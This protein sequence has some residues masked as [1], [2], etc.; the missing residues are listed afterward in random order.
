[1]EL[2]ERYLNAVRFWLPAEQQ[3]DIIAEL[4][5]DLR[6]EISDREADL[7]RPLGE[8]DLTA[9]LKRR[10]DPVAVA[11]RF[12]DMK[13][14]IGSALMPI[15]WYV[16]QLVT[17][18]ILIP[19]FGL[20][21]GPIE[22]AGQTNPGIAWGATLWQLLMGQVFAFGVITVIFAMLERS[23]V[24]HRALGKSVNGW[25]PSKL[26]S[27]PAAAARQTKPTPRSRS[28]AEMAASAIVGLW[29]MAILWG[30]MRVDL[31]GI[32]LAA[33][34]IWTTLRGLILIPYLAGFAAAWFSL[35]RPYSIRA[36]TWFQAGIDCLNLTLLGILLGAGEWVTLQS[37]GLNAGA[38]ADAVQW[39][40][41]GIRIG[42]GIGALV[43]GY[44][45]VGKVL[46]LSRNRL[47]TIST[48]T[49]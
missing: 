16:V 3:D 48:Q 39:S 35:V 5:D 25:D 29:I 22:M 34:P 32:Q 6:A 12:L 9:I 27:L 31:N 17:L 36:R 23:D 45:L 13:P 40:N 2:L 20:I 7:G 11:S 15:Y 43:T 4:S 14:L 47:K 18:W 44:S 28:I 38:L 24:L 37:S 42:L 30:P 1:M 19:V 49:V 8:A 10:G 26:P 46:E 41:F 33:A 21:V